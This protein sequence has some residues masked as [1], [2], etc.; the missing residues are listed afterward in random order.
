MAILAQDLAHRSGG[1]YL[2]RIEDTDTTREV[3][4][5]VADFDRLFGHFGLL[6]DEDD[7][8]GAWGP[9]RQSRRESV[10]LSFVRDLVRRGL[11][12]PCFC[13]AETLAG[14]AEEQ[15]RSRSSLGYY[16]RWARCRSL[17]E[18]EVDRRVASGAPF[19]VRFRC[20]AGLPGRVRFQDRIRGP[21][22]MLDNGNDV[23]ILK[24]AD[25]GRGCPPTT[26]PMW[27]TTI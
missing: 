6:P 12:Y 20:P 5:A 25:G 16:G 24:S 1:T 18:A 7:V 3:S 9:Y 26:S 19:T 22:T 4:G 13:D 10:Y 11:A 14:N 17:A 23:V 21:L 8:N 27:S 15:R 2:V